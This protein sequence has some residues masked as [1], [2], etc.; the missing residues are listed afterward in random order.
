MTYGSITGN[1]FGR[2]QGWGNSA[3]HLSDCS[4]TAI[5]GNQFENSDGGDG[6]IVLLLSGSATGVSI[7]SN[8]FSD[9]Y[10]T[11]LGIV[12]GEGGR[13]AGTAVLANT[14]DGRYHS[15]ERAVVV[16]GK[17]LQSLFIANN[18]LNNYVEDG[19]I[20]FD[21]QEGLVVKDNLVLSPVSKEEME[22][23][24]KDRRRKFGPPSE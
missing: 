1:I 8:N 3:V 23:R 22:R 12:P 18:T 21:E 2:V 7:T 24:N 15:H 14:F 6:G 11:D 13:V 10:V 9:N 16:K 20:L 17:G 4:A 19:A 5:V